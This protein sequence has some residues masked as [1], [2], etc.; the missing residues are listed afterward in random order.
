MSFRKTIPIIFI[1]VIISL[2]LVFKSNP[3][4]VRR[5]ISGS[6]EYIRKGEAL[7]DK[8]RYK[9]AIAYFEK[10][11]EES[12]ENKEITAALSWAYTKY[13][14]TLADRGD[15]D[16]AIEYLVKAYETKGDSAAAQNLAII[17]SKRSLM[18][19]RKENWAEAI[20]NLRNASSIVSEFSVA[21]R[22]LAISLFNDAVEEY[23]HN[24]KN[25]ALLWL[26]ES[27]LLYDESRILEFMGEIYYRDRALEKAYFYWNRAKALGPDSASL[28]EKL[29][30]AE[31]EMKLA[32]V[33]ERM[34]SPHFDIRFEKGLAIDT[35]LTNR[36]LEN[37]YF[38]VGTSL[39]YFPPSK[40]VV[41]FYSEDNFRDVFKLPSIVAAFYDGNIRM[42]YPESALGK[43]ELRRYIYHE[44]THAVVS[45]KTNNNCPVWFSE[46]I[47]TWEEFK[48]WGQAAR[49]LLPKTEGYELT[50]RYLKDGYATSDKGKDLRIHYLLSS[51]VVEYIVETWGIDGLRD[52]LKRMADGQHITNAID[53]EF[54]LSEKEFTKR[55][56]D[57][58]KAKRK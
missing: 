58:V 20:E 50:L 40:T 6:F 12:G 52:I 9:D 7:L 42:P 25:I 43:D 21:G 1:C 22:N 55:W 11:F 45:A 36:I 49:E 54:L 2:I 57:Y 3:G 8:G 46:G 5:K 26:K 18:A 35:K 39:A 14:M 17:Y 23:K 48:A 31:R 29:E 32:E 47:A 13:A 16:Q 56:S 27:A 15:Y 24:R 37:A 38:D 19:A 4:L 41:F 44:Y 51:T 34:D 33:E 10:A 53:D 28:A 30:K